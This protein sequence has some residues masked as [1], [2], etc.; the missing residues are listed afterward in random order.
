MGYEEEKMRKYTQKTEE[1]LSMV[2]EP[3]TGSAYNTHVS[4]P[5]LGDWWNR[6]PEDEKKKYHRAWLY[7][8]YGDVKID[9]YDEE[10]VL[11]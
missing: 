4:E 10:A 8:I 3:N 2:N 1:T 6:V 5:L 7:H 11:K 9:I